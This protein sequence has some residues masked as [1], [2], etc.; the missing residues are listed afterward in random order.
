MTA[1][2]QG[3][4]DVT[5]ERD[6]FSI[7]YSRAERTLSWR[8]AG[9]WDLE[10]VGAFLLAMRD[11]V[12]PLGPPPLLMKGL[13][14]SREFP[15]QAPAVADALTNVNTLAQRTRRGPTAIVVGSMLNKLQAQRSLPDPLLEVFL[16]I[17]EARSWLAAQPLN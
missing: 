4:A 8:M 7:S 17:D 2:E 13:C 11:I 10:D 3:G 6:K 5:V 1:C 16:D 15:V 9:F 12:V 14:D